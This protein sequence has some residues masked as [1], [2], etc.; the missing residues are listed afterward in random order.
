M[1]NLDVLKI[2]LYSLN[3]TLNDVIQVTV[4]DLN[5]FPKGLPFTEMNKYEKRYYKQHIK[6]FFFKTK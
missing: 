1:G 2:W 4:A 6:S 5:K 3:Y